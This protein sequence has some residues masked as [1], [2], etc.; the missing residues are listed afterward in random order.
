MPAPLRRLL[1]HNKPGATELKITS[2]ESG[3]E[4]RRK[5]VNSGGDDVGY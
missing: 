3:K 1:S 5:P 4:T 2:K